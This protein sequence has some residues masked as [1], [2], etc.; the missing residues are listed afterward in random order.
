M[1]AV[2]PSK[3]KCF[4]LPMLC[5]VQGES[6]DSIAQALKE[7]DNNVPLATRILRAR[8][9]INGQV[10][11]DT[12]SRVPNVCTLLQMRACFQWHDMQAPLCPTHWSSQAVWTVWQNVHVFFPLNLDGNQHKMTAGLGTL[13]P[14]PLQAPFRHET[15][16]SCNHV[17]HAGVPPPRRLRGG[18]GEVPAQAAEAGVQT[19]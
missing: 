18:G 8:R 10:N 7:A 9:V 6:E 5:P 15:P 16:K 11:A 19:H 2:L 1:C 12:P 3:E 14:P 4:S 13:T 17:W